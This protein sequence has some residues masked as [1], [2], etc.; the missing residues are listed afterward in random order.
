MICVY[1]SYRYIDT[2]QYR[3]GLSEMM[4]GPALFF[5]VISRQKDMTVTRG[6]GWDPLNCQML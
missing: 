3:F 4:D 1:K 2:Q 5:F 6:F